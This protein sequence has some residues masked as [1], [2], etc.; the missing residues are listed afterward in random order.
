MSKSSRRESAALPRGPGKWRNMKNDQAQIAA[1]SDGMPS[2]TIAHIS[3]RG[4]SND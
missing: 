3:V 4:K 1:S 2:V